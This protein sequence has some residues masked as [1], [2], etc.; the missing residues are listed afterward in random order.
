MLGRFG[1][2]NPVAVS[3]LYNMASTDSTNGNVSHQDVQEY[4][5][6]TVQS[7]Q[8][9]KTN[10]CTIQGRL[11]MKKSIKQALAAVHD[12]VKAT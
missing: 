11:K 9:L 8:D 4:Y 1:K 5:G 12:D 6:K 10:V 3:L 2:K 7:T